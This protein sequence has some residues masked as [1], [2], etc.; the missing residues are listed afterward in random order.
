MENLHFVQNGTLYS[1]RKEISSTYQNW[2][3]DWTEVDLIHDRKWTHSIAGSR[4]DKSTEIK[5]NHKVGFFHRYF[6]T[7]I[8]ENCKPKFCDIFWLLTSLVF[9][10]L[11]GTCTCIS[12]R[13]LEI[14]SEKW[15][16]FLMDFRIKFG[17]VYDYKKHE[18]K[19]SAKEKILRS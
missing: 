17:R 8:I 12:F 6:D 4:K 3:L 5:I 16:E 2:P 14:L 11:L 1:Q 7:D 9:L 15:E 10:F 18:M 13:I 19:N